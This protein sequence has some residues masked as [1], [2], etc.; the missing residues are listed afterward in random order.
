MSSSCKSLLFLLQR[1]VAVRQVT[2]VTGITTRGCVLL[3]SREFVQ[4]RTWTSASRTPSL[5]P[6]QSAVKSSQ[7]GFCTKVS[8]SPTYLI[9]MVK[10]ADC[11]T[12]QTGLTKRSFNTYIL[13][14]VVTFYLVIRA[15]R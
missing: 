12:F 7:Y 2:S 13:L 4:R 14:K 1:C 3:S 11:I 10:A 8:L 15:V 6:L 9:T 5:C